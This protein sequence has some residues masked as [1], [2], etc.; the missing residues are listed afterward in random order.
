VPVCLLVLVLAGCGADGPQDEPDE[1]VVRAELDVETGAVVLPY[2]A[3]RPSPSELDLLA[4]ASSAVVADCGDALGIDFEPLGET[5]DDPVYASEP[6]FGP[7]T[8]AQ[9]DRFGFVQPQS[10][11]DLVVNGI[12]DHANG[13]GDAAGGPQPEA[14]PNA[15]LTDEDWSALDA[16]VTSDERAVLFREAA[17]QSGPWTQS[18]EAISSSLSSGPPGAAVLADLVACYEERGMRPGTDEPW[19]PLGADALAI[20]ATQI[21]MAGAVVECKVGTDFTQRMADI[22]ASQQAEVIREYEADLV[23]QRERLDEAL[24]VAQG[25]VPGVTGRG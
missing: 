11:R 22:E 17:V 21:A 3:Y 13:S 4:V 2:D 23:L 9:A 20:D 12:T 24:H 10:D 14:P 8:L 6:Y 16:C 1:V 18:I 7:W 25:L 19:Y 15:S 5:L